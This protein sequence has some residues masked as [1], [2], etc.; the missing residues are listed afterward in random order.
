MALIVPQRIAPKR[1]LPLHPV[2]ANSDAVSGALRFLP[3]HP[4][5]IAHEPTALLDIHRYGLNL[6]LWLAGSGP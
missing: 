3:A 2:P 5:G 1:R 6:A 4:Q